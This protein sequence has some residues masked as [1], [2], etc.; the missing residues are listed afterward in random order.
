MND[1]IKP[2]VIIAIYGALIATFT[3]IWNIVEYK[4]K[5]KT[6]LKVDYFLQITG[7]EDNNT[8]IGTLLI[9]IINVGQVEVYIDSISIDLCGKKI[10]LQNGP[11]AIIDASC[12]GLL[13]QPHLCLN[14]GCIKESSII[15]KDLVNYIDDKL[16]D[17][18][19]LKITV[20]DS[21]G[22]QYHSTKFSYKSLKE[23]ASIK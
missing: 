3:F 23:F 6:S 7:R 11:N 10:K 1:W 22:H 13:A 19:K 16:K 8:N 14:K 20:I 18:E 17:Y 12:F 21:L 15:I 4:N 9:R 5:T 2:T